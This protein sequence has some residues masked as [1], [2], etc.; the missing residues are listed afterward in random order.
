MDLPVYVYV[1]AFV[2][3]APVYIDV[4]F[5]IYLYISRK[6][7]SFSFLNIDLFGRD[8]EWEHARVGEGAEAERPEQSPAECG[9]H[10]VGGG[11][12]S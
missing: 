9:A 1:G 12:L 8:R 6:L 10:G 3:H 4:D 5:Y 2:Q 7:S 11:C